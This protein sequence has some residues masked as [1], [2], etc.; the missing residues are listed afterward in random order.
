MSA[1]SCA[2]AA[3]REVLEMS[4]VITLR[5]YQ[6]AER[7]LEV[8]HARTGLAIH[9]IVTVLVWAALIAI[10]VVVAPQ[11]P[12]SPFPVVG[13]GIGL[14]FHYIAVR[15]IDRAVTERQAQIETLAQ[16]HAA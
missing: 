15:R 9:A 1:G 7:D 6:Q 2:G 3:S 16:R 11:F 12:W 13:M 5:A 14:A 8:A 10:N 4:D